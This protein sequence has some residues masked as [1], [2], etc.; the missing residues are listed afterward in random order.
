MS[1]AKIWLINQYASTPETGQGGRHYYFARL[2]AQRG[3]E[4]FV[5]GAREHHLLTRPDL[6]RQAPQIEDIDGYRFVRLDALRYKGPH[7][8]RRI[9]GWFSFAWQLRK[10]DRIIGARPDTICVSSLSLVSY[11]GAEHLARRLDARLV[12]EVRDLWPLTAIELGNYCRNHPFV[13]FLQWVE[14][15]GY[16]NADHV[17]STLSNAY[18]HME[19][20]GLPPDRYT[21]IPNGVMPDNG[22]GEELDAAVRNVIPRSGFVVGY[23]GTFGLANS[24]E[25]ILD[26]A[27]RLKN[28]PEIKFVLIGAGPRKNVLLADAQARGLDN[29]IFAGFIPKAQVQSAIRHF[30]ACVICWDDN[31]LYRFGTSANKLAEYMLSGKPIVQAYSGANDLV[32]EHGLGYTVPAR[33][34]EALADAIIRLSRDSEETRKSMGRHGRDLATDGYS[35]PV[36]CRR[37]EEIVAG[38]NA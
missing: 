10:L 26:V 20:H 25:T 3:H 13:R 4:V 11:L 31:P 30:S 18:A 27:E 17:I 7:D 19:K 8:K 33:D 22:P 15:R 34:G 6:S 29:V 35:Y 32:A 1:V 9:F 2:L 24:L 16:R 14:D 36:L 38:R 5:I 23:T 37:F 28:N 12:F 21:W